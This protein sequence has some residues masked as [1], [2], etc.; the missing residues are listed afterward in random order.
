MVRSLLSRVVFGLLTLS[1]CS[2]GS[3]VS[4]GSSPQIGIDAPADN[5]TVGGVVSIDLTVIDDFGVDQVRVLID[6]NEIAKLFT[7]PFHT[8]WNTVGLADNSLHAIKVEATDLSGNIAIKTI[9]VTV[10]N[11]PQSPPR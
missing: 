5:A 8:N 4:D 3:D 1:A 2:L 10:V 7:P 11:A 6:E 9:H